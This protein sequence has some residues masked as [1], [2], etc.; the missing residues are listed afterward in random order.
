MLDFR[1]HTFL[2]VVKYMNFS[3]AAKELCITQPAVS[4]QIK[5]LEQ[6]YNIK[7]FTYANKQL[8]LTKEGHLFYT[9]ANAF[10]ND[11]KAFVTALH[12]VS[13]N[14]E[15]YRVGIT[16]TVCEYILSKPLVQFHKQNKDIRLHI[17]MANTKTLLSYLRNGEIDFAFIEGFYPKDEFKGY[18]Y[19]TENFIA[20]SNSKHTF[21]K[22]VHRLKDLTNEPLILREMGSG[23]RD[24]FEKALAIQ[25]LSITDFNDIT[26]IS[27]MPTIVEFVKEDCGITFL[28]ESAVS[29]ELNKNIL[30]RIDLND[31][32]IQH[33][34][35][36]VMNK[37]T[38]NKDIYTN[39]FE[40]LKQ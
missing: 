4:Q 23:T 12:A 2:C 30:K 20:V 19:R 25:D 17:V 9:K 31:F 35:H 39:I 11:E 29:N 32:N 15:E 21:T 3:K 6:Q 14:K 18:V 1:I 24:I 36:F 10:V 16:N 33:E 38:T 7:L 8:H 28:Y 26:Y 34:I 40:K 22:E 13:T 5:Y 27:C 37:D